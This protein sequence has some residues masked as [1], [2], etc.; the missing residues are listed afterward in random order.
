M[1]RETFQLLVQ[2]NGGSRLQSVGKTKLLDE[3]IC[4]FERCRK[5]LITSRKLGEL[6]GKSMR[7]MNKSDI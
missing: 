4:Y 3:G 7:A 1:K 2:Q 5:L 6:K